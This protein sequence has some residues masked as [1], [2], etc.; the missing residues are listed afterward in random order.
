M[1]KQILSL[2]T[3]ALAVSLLAGTALAQQRTPAPEEKKA[4]SQALPEDNMPV[5]RTPT[6]PIPM[7]PTGMVGGGRVDP[8]TGKYI[9]YN[10]ARTGLGF[11][12]EKQEITDYKTGKVYK[13]S[14]HPAYN[15]PRKDSKQEPKKTI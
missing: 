11:N 6:T 3:P 9:L 2:L 14:E 5:L 7:P 12:F 4:P 1:K 8:K 15:A 10:D 13:F